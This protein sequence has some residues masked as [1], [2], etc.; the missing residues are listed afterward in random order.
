M[1]CRPALCSLPLLALALPAALALPPAPPAAEAPGTAFRRFE[2]R[3]IDEGLG[4]RFADLDG[5]GKPALVVAPLMG[6][7]STPAKNWTDGRPVRLAAYH[8]PG[9]PGRDRWVPE[10][11]DE[12]RHVMHNFWPIPAASGKGLDVLTAS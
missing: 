8:I 3:E 7:K 1:R 6:E 10:V 5:S 9:D 12:T 11:L 4:I 2:K